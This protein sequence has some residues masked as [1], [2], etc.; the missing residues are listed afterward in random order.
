MKQEDNRTRPKRSIRTKLFSALTVMIVI[1]LALLWLMQVVLFDIIY[2]NVRVSEIEATARHIRLFSDQP[3]F[4]RTVSESTSQ[5]DICADVIRADG[6][7]AYEVENTS[8]CL[9]HSLT[10]SERSELVAYAG[11]TSLF[12]VNYDTVTDSYSLEAFSGSVL[13]DA[14]NILY[15]ESITHNSETLYLILDAT[16]SPV[17]TVKKASASFLIILSGV[18]IGVAVLLANFLSKSIAEPICEISRRAKALTTGSYTAVESHS[19]ELDELNASLLAA[20]HDLEKVE[21]MRRELI[22]NLSHDLRTPLT[23]IGGYT[24]MMRDLPSE[25]TEENLDTVLCE[26]RRLTSLV[27]DMMDIAMLESGKTVPKPEIFDLTKEVGEAVG[28]YGRLTESE[29]YHFSF[30]ADENATVYADKT[31]ILQVLTNLLNN[32]MTYTGDDASVSVSQTLNDAFVRIEVTDTGE[33]ISPDA[34]PMIWE[35][36][37]K[38]DAAHKRAAKGTGL[39]LSIVRQV[40]TAH[41]GR[42]GVRST[43]GKGSTFWFELPLYSPGLTDEG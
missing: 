10:V 31:M 41:S 22:A 43:V 1:T 33:G 9:L 4:F 5:N 14:S 8:T 24:E 40:I 32:A 6:S 35:R 21:H 26:I 23:L 42:Y 12:K 18:L 17:G 3:N 37:Y 39:G 38:V 28:R 36:Y 11:E 25:I 15:I 13:T 27:N 2:T 29:G 30:S 19:T 34:L 20:S 7:I 16:V